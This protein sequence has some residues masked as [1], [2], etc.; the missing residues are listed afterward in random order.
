MA[1]DPCDRH[2]Q[3]R[4]PV[5]REIA[6]FRELSKNHP[7]VAKQTSYARVISGEIPILFDY[8]FNAYR[9][10]YTDKAPVRF[11]IPQEGTVVFPY[12]MGLVQG[13]P[14]PDNA[15]KVLDFV[16]SDRSQTS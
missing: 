3:C 2:G 14:N 15:K 13:G 9:G 1:W 7:I 16:L 10:Q 5:K 4:C 8:D 6:Y 11:V 12:V